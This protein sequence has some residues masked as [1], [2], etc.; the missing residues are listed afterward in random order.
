MVDDACSTALAGD[1]PVLIRR[2]CQC[3]VVVSPKRPEA[4]WQLYREFGVDVIISDDGLQ[5]YALDRDIELVVIDGGRRFGNGHLLP[6]GPLREGV[7][8]LNSADFIICNGGTAQPGEY[9]MELMADPLKNLKDPSLQLMDKR[10]NAVA[11]IG[12]PQRFF[13]SLEGLGYELSGR[14][15]FADHH[16]Y[17]SEELESL[18]RELPLLMTEKDAVKCHGFARDN[19]WYLPVS[20]RF[21]KPLT[22]AIV[23]KIKEKTDGFG[24][25]SV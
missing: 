8:R 11:A 12:N 4:A 24:S 6:M 18:S 23:T 7:W 9:E 10:V 3:P 14:Y 13:E 15:A 1:E 21:D 5:H 22:E 16:A 2:R 20:A 19:W 17:Q 25:S